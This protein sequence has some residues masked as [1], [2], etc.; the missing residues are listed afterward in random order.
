M[1]GLFHLGPSFDDGAFLLHWKIVG[2]L[3]T[4]FELSVFFVFRET[5]ENVFG[6][7]I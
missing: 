7:A 2:I 6:D 1:E 3:E 5:V 4:D